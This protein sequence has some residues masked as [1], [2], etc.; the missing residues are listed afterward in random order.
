MSQRITVGLVSL[1]EITLPRVKFLKP[2]ENNKIA[3]NVKGLKLFSTSE[4][5]YQRKRLKYECTSSQTWCYFR[6]NG[7]QQTSPEKNINNFD[8]ALELLNFGS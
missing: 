4:S 5:S 3:Q 8:L 1:S 7:H 6:T 2:P